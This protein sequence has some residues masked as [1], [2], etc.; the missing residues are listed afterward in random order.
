[1]AVKNLKVELSVDNSELQQAIAGY[2]L[3]LAK[4]PENIFADLIKHFLGFLFRL[5]LKFSVCSG[6]SAA[7]ANNLV[8]TFRLS[9]ILKLFAATT[10]AN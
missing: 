4:L 5:G 3:I 10:S 6:C 2:E 7:G 8:V 9:W 1:M